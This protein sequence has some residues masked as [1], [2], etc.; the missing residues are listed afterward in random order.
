MF[1][2]V[3]PFQPT[4]CPAGCR[5]THVRDGQYRRKSDGALVQRFRCPQC[6]K[7]FSSA[8]SSECFGQKKRYLNFEVLKLLC[9]GLSQ[10]RAALHLSTNRKTIERKFIWM[11]RRAIAMLPYFQYGLPQIDHI[12]FDDME[13]F[14]HT[15]CKP[16]SITLAVAHPGRRILGFRVSD[17]PAKGKLAR[18]SVKKYGPR[19]DRR[20]RARESL[21]CELKPL[22]SPEAVI[23]SD[24]NPHYGPDVAAHFPGHRHQVHKGR[25]GCVVGQGELKRGGFDPLFSLNHTCAMLRDSI[26]R[27]ARRTWCTTKKP[28]RLAYHVAI[29]AFYHNI[30]LI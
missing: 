5:I 3:D 1:P 18:I 6:G 23:S 17:M 14:V 15:K 11:G 20:P 27:L 28:E 8:T 21:F 13:T 4:G 22:L 30:M 19:R 7:R 24:M 29:Y 16:L 2:F 26:K 10:R 25:R 9:S 12:Q